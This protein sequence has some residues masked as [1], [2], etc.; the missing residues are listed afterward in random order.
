MAPKLDTIII[1]SGDGD[2]VPL[3]EYL[4]NYQG[5]QVEIVSFGKSSSS[6]LI[7]I[8][9]DFLDLD[10]NPKKYLLGANSSKGSRKSSEA[11]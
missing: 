9:D 1:L 2:F 10:T 8:A 4:K 6:R 7:D 3:V 5:C 11:R